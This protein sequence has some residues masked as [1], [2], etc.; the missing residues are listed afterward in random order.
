MKAFSCYI[1]VLSKRLKQMK[2]ILLC[3]NKDRLLQPQEFHLKSK[4][5]KERLSFK[6][7]LRKEI[8]FVFVNSPIIKLECISSVMVLVGN[9]FILS[10]VVKLNKVLRNT[11]RVELMTIWGFSVLSVEKRINQMHNLIKMPSKKIVMTKE[12]VSFILEDL[13]DQVIK[14]WI[15]FLVLSLLSLMDNLSLLLSN[16]SVKILYRL[17]AWILCLWRV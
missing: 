14:Q 9:C 3:P 12:M 7:K 1:W 10:A 8:L 4:E 6:M 11:F 2:R 5:L 16:N 17:K 15:R 13:T